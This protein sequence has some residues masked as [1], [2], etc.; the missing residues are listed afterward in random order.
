MVVFYCIN[1]LLNLIQQ[2]KRVTNRKYNLT[3]GKFASELSY[4]FIFNL[5]YSVRSSTTRPFHA[6]R[7][8]ALDTSSLT[9]KAAES[10]SPWPRALPYITLNGKYILK[11]KMNQGMELSKM[12]ICKFDKNVT[13][14][15]KNPHNGY[16]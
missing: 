15:H 9:P 14:G 16:L 12:A 5:F 2:V 6:S 3:I 1:H 11:K 13:Y 4:G 10:S 8:Q 7:C